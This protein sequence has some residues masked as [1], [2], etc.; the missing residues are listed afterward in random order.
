[1]AKFHS[2]Q[3]LPEGLVLKPGALD[4]SVGQP[5]DVRDGDTVRRGVVT[6]VDIADDGQT[7]TLI[8]DVPGKLDWTLRG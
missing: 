5:I 8:I 3:P 4:G 6:G 2:V 7:F 1:M